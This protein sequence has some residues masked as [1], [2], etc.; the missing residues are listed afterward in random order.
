MIKKIKNEAPDLRRLS[1]DPMT[2]LNTGTMKALVFGNLDK[3]F[4][5]MMEID[6]IS[7]DEKEVYELAVRAFINDISI[8]G[9]PTIHLGRYDR[10]LQCSL[11]TFGLTEKFN[12]M[13]NRER[14][15]YP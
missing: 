2:G 12:E 9:L 1:E 6:G 5:M 10:E 14:E 11:T 4:D 3:Y 15:Y 8:N 7:D 13:I